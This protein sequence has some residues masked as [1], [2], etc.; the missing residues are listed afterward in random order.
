MTGAFAAAVTVTL[1]PAGNVAGE[2]EADVPAGSP[3][4]DGVMS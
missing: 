4:N 3:L 2:K 1:W